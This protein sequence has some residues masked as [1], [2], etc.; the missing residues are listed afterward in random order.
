VRT[1]TAE[2]AQGAAVRL[3]DERHH[4]FAADEPEDLGGTDTAPAPYDLLLGALAACTSVTVS[5]QAERQGWPF[6]GIDVTTAH[7]RIRAEDCP[8]CDGSE[9][10]FVDRIVSEVTIYG[11]F[12]ARQRDRL[13][14]AATSCPVHRTLAGGAHLVDRIT[15]R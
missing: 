14:R 9:R 7:E 15:F 8:D 6:A 5:L 3:T 13:T 10:G 11:T 4:V 12:D 1:V 2:L